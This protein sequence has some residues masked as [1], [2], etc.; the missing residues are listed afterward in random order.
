MVNVEFTC[1]L[2]VIS[3]RSWTKAFEC[4]QKQNITAAFLMCTVSELDFSVY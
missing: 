1:H 4:T 2:V 3:F